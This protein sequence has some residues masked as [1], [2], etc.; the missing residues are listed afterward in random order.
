MLN[1]CYDC[2]MSTSAYT[3]TPS[4]LVKP[5]EYWDVPLLATKLYIPQPRL[6]RVPR[7]H[8]SQW[9][10]EGLRLGHRLALISAPAGYGKTTLLSEWCYR[11]SH[12]HGWLLAWLSLD[13]S[14]NDPVRFWRYVIAALQTLQPGLGENV[15]S[16][17]QSPQQPSMQAMLT[18]LINE[19]VDTLHN[20][21]T[22]PM[23]DTTTLSSE[24]L[25]L[26]APPPEHHLVLILDDYHAIKDPMIHE[27]VMFLIDN[28]PPRSRAQMHLVIA[29]RADPPLSLA[30]LRVRGQLTEIRVAD[31]RFTPDETA[32]FLNQIMGLS[33]SAEDIVTLKLRTEG[34]IAGLQLAA[35]SMRDREDVADF[36]A[37][38]SGSHRHV[39]DYLAEEVISKQSDEIHDFLCQTAIL[40]Q[41]TAP[42]CDAVTG[43]DDSRE[44]LAQL[45][46]ANLFLIPLDDSRAWYRYHHLFVDLLRQRLQQIQP[47]RIPTLHSRASLWYAQR[48][49]L[50]EAIEH[51]LSSGDL[52]QAA[53]LIEEAAEPTMMRS[54]IATFQSW[55]EALPDAIMRGRPLL[56]VFHAWTL[57]LSGQPYEMVKARL[58][59]AAKSADLSPGKV[60]PLQAFVAAFQGKFSQAYKL[61]SQAQEQLKESD[62]FWHGVILWNLGISL[63]IKGDVVNACAAFEEVVKRGIESGN[64]LVAVLG[65]CNRAELTAIQGQLYTAEALYQSALDMAKDKYGR[66]LP[67]AG[68]VLVGLGELF[69]EWDDLD[70]A[71]GYIMEGIELTQHWAE[72]SFLYAYISMSRIKLA[73]SDVR[74]AREALQQAQQ[75]A[76]RFD[77]TELDDV[78]VAL[79][80]ARLE[81][82][83]AN[84]APARHWAEARGLNVENVMAELTRVEEGETDF[85]SYYLRELEYLTFIRLLIAQGEFQNA[86]TLLE[87][88]RPTAEGQWRYGNVIEMQALKALACQARNVLRGSRVQSTSPV[89]SNS[90][91][92]MSALERALSLAEPGGYIRTFVDLGPP[93]AA[94]LRQAL[95]QNI[96]PGYVCQLLAAFGD[97]VDP[98]PIPKSVPTVGE[99]SPASLVEP[100]TERELEV[101]QLIAAGLSNREIA[102]AL[103]IAIS[104]VKTHINNIYGKLDV[105]SRTQALARARDLNLV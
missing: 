90:V 53:D 97:E 10:D 91:Q 6:D 57:L 9:L 76:I 67:I 23:L 22:E 25:H 36:I 39:L 32:I 4:K 14:D 31:L 5:P 16:L 82:A 58:E 66:P 50:A 12:D 101:L 70:A 56:C 49:M 51:A 69:R 27:A 95:A 21:P 94:L 78:F 46:Q 20:L 92:A 1:P 3:E 102:E 85:Y 11:A 79:I 29:T 72:I 73:Q 68:M 28:L 104:T 99:S 93:M 34:W 59:D 30:R 62:A 100:L 63:A 33:L 48:G 43:R 2:G 7:P 71:L 44:I 75:V 74:S 37:D 38:F 35:L 8:L 13:E 40:D 103:F 86:L 96:A 15:L 88:M 52:A 18:L 80:Q 64:I 61:S 45:E 55:V 17:L 89:D 87:Q 41:L 24:G 19:L 54:E 26:P 42:L 98:F 60:T 65:Q 47:E 84:L 83:Q 77:A 81:I 105:S